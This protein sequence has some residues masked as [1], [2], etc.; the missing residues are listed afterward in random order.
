MTHSTWA[1]VVHTL[2][3]IGALLHYTVHTRIIISIEYWV[4]C[5]AS[6]SNVRPYAIVSFLSAL[7]LYHICRHDDSSIGVIVSCMYV[8]SAT[9]DSR[10]PPITKAEFPS[11]HCAVSLLTKFEDARDYLDWQVCH[12]I[13]V[14][15]TITCFS[16]WWCCY[17]SY[18]ILQGKVA[19]DIS[20]G[21]KVFAGFFYSLFQNVTEGRLLR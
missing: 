14:T 1:S 20:R 3:K 21:G 8:C 10:F 13:V 5:L 18:C 4:A 7:C 17:Y 9:R 16:C 6:D 2:L 12:F 11:L 19:A 15:S